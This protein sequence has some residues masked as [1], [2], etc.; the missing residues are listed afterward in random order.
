MYI[1][2]LTTADIIKLSKMLVPN[3]ISCI[4][5][6]KKDSIT[7]VINQK[8]TDLEFCLTDFDIVAQNKSAKIWMG[9]FSLDHD[10]YKF[11]SEK[12]G[13]EYEN[14]YFESDNSFMK[15][16]PNFYNA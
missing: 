1:E 16:L 11:M 2:K 15:S 5:I 12:F 13:E 8:N 10:Y 9:K 3:N 4:F 7:L 14:G 6:K